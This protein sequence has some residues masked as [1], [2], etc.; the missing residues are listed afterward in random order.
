MPP[1]RLPRQDARCSPEAPAGFCSCVGGCNGDTGERRQKIRYA[2]T[3]T[4]SPC[5]WPE[6]LKERCFRTCSSSTR[7]PVYTARI[8]M[9]CS[10]LCRLQDLDSASWNQRAPLP[11]PSPHMKHEKYY[12]PMPNQ[13]AR[14]SLFTSFCSFR[15][16]VSNR[17]SVSA[18]C[19]PNSSN[20]SWS[21]AVPPQR[22][23]SR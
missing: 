13:R 18:L 12:P 8:R 22:P 17:V 15:E 10:V 9:G 19:R 21:C 11:E 6:R 1:A 2:V 7:T 3:L 5:A 4:L 23:A 14:R 16:R 20:S